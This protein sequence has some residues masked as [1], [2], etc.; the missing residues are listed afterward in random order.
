MRQRV[1]GLP[2]R[3]TLLRV[4]T[5]ASFVTMLSAL[6]SGLAWF[7]SRFV[8]RTFLVLGETLPDFGN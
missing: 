2:G 4:T 5:A 6:G 1:A 7:V 3:T 8:R